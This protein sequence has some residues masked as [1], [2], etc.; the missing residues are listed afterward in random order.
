MM[1]INYYYYYYYDH[2][3]WVIFVAMCLSELQ[4]KASDF[5]N[6]CNGPFAAERWR[7]TKSPNWRANDALGHVEQREFKFGGFV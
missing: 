5:T 6:S 3:N 4:I 2:G 7:G 1:I